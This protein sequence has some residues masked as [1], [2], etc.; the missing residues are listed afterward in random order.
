M[1][2]AELVMSGRLQALLV[3]AALGMLGQNIPSIL[4]P[5]L[6]WG[7][8]V[9]VAL[10]VL[11]KGF[12]E[13]IWP[14]TGALVPVGMAWVAG[15]M[16]VMGALVGG[17]A[18]ALVL[19]N[20]RQ[21]DFA[22]LMVAFVAVLL[23]GAIGFFPEQTALLYEQFNLMLEQLKKDGFE[24][25]EIE[26]QQ[27]LIYSI[28]WTSAW[29]GTTALLCA[30]WLQAK[31]YNPGG[32]QKEFHQL[33][34]SQPVLGVLMVGIVI[35]QVFPLMEGVLPV[36][37]MP[38]LLAGF[39]LIHGVAKIKGLGKRPIVLMYGSIALFGPFALLMVTVAAITDSFSN[40][41][42]K[43]LPPES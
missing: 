36:L 41:R 16:S 34:V 31:L 27:F 32:F 11:R 19:A 9:L 14:F 39:A 22:L 17:F 29:M 5:M 12:S 25:F 40:Y 18:G 26:S 8:I 21:L 4:G 7:A 6:T 10:V 33:R 13:A 23:K 35:G 28:V 37:L 2:L 15:D 24:Q 3:T 42:D 43:M 30:R 38:I 20:T 1:K